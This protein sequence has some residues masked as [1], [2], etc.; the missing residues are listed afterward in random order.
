MKL[1]Y[2]HAT[3]AKATLY[4]FTMLDDFTSDSELC[5]YLFIVASLLSNELIKHG[6]VILVN[7]LHLIDV[8]GHLL[9]GFQSL[10]GD[11]SRMRAC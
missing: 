11:E 10:C 3:V 5:V 7:L 2:I 8:T 1:C 6:A 9:H 4:M